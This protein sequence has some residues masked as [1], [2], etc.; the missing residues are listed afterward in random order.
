MLSQL[1]INGGVLVGPALVSLALI[2]GGISTRLIN[3]ND[4]KDRTIL[5]AE[6]GIVLLA[7]SCVWMFVYLFWYDSID[8]LRLFAPAFVSLGIIS[9]GVYRIRHDVNFTGVGYA[10]TGIALYSGSLV[11]I[12]WV[13]QAFS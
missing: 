7:L 8:Y 6:I 1:C 9:A 4:L 5:V 13:L 11:W 10:Y 3:W 2:I 12:Y